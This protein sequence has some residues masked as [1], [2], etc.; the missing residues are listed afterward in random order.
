MSAHCDCDM[1]LFIVWMMAGIAEKKTARGNE[2][3][4]GDEGNG[5]NFGNFC[6]AVDE[7][8]AERFILES[9]TVPRGFAHA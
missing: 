5:D 6:C 8:G 2:R 7:D 3:L 9:D 1:Q 4:E